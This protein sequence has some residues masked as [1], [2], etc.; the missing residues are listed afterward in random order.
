M[1]WK[2]TSYQGRIKTFGALSQR[3]IRNPNRKA[4]PKKN[5]SDSEKKSFFITLQI[6]DDLF[7]LSR[8]FSKRKLTISQFW[9]LKTQLGALK[10]VVGPFL[11]E[12]IWSI[13]PV[14]T[15]GFYIS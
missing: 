4:I 10:N 14:C 12:E 9:A 1:F 15:K 2:N 8:L 11:P 7:L 13:T 6:S 5:F 3:H